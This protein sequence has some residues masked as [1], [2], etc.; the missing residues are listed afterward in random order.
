MCCED[1]AEATHEGLYCSPYTRRKV[2]MPNTPRL[3]HSH[4]PRVQISDVHQ[5]LPLKPRRIAR[6]R[7]RDPPPL[8]AR[9]HRGYGLADWKPSNVFEDDCDTMN[10]LHRTRKR[11]VC[12]QAVMERSLESRS[13]CQHMLSMRAR[14]RTQT[15]TKPTPTRLLAIAMRMS[16]Q[17]DYEDCRKRGSSAEG[18]AV[19]PLY[20]QRRYPI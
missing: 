16:Q 14:P 8:A 4:P 3:S 12:G 18:E 5:R 2:S 6:R 13:S 20:P 1:N 10:Q 7:S 19:T 15:Q 11:N 9:L 17:R